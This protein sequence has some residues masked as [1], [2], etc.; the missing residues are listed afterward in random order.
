MPS[1]HLP[2]SP[3]SRR[4][5]AVSALGLAMLPGLA[6]QPQ[7]AAPV[8]VPAAGLSLDAK[9]SEHLRAQALQTALNALMTLG[10]ACY[11]GEPGVCNSPPRPKPKL[12]AD[13]M[14]ALALGLRALHDWTGLPA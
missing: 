4:R 14:Q 1:N 8:G 10:A 5:A 9:R 3:L 2:V 12:G 6:A 11:P 13:E 7:K